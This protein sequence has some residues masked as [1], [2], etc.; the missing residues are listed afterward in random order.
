M[1]GVSTIIG[2]LGRSRA[3]LRAVVAA[4]GAPE[5]LVWDDADGQLAVYAPATRGLAGH[6]PAWVRRVREGLDA[7]GVRPLTVIA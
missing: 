3:T 7:A 4:A 5:D 1:L 2:T 6:P